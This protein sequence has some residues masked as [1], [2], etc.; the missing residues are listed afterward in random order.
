MQGGKKGLIVNSR[1]LCAAVSR[2]S[3]SLE[4]HNG[5]GLSLRP[6]MRPQCAKGASAAGRGGQR[7]AR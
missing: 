2:A 3:V 6:Q 5:A 4:A 7:R 1:D